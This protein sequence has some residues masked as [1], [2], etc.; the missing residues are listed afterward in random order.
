ML[1]RPPPLRP[2][3]PPH[4]MTTRSQRGIYK[5]NPKYSFQA[6]PV[7]HSS[8]SPIPKDP[9]SALCDPNWKHAMQEEFDALIENH[10]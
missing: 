7:I 2:T 3:S 8:P 5:P 6:F 4:G 9:I 10:T 1:Y